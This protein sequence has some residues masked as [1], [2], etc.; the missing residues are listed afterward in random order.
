MDSEKLSSVNPRAT[1]AS[2]TTD[3][4]AQKPP[5]PPILERFRALLKQRDDELRASAGGG[6][7]VGGD[8]DDDDEIDES[9]VVPP[10]SSEE[11]VELY[12][13]FLGELTFNSK[14]VI[15]DLTIIAGEQKEHGKGIA[16]AICARI[17][18]VRFG[19]CGILGEE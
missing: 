12:E 18:E 5:P 17:I 19:V 15:T 10:P 16:D 6:G 2:A 3:L 1:T 11:I 14:P 7:G 13:M 9:F 8:D 4:A